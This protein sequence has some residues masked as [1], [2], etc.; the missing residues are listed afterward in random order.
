MTARNTYA[1]LAEYK[2]F[3]MS[4]GQPTNTDATD[5]AVIDSLLEQASRYIDGKTSRWFYPRI[6]TRYLS[7]PNYPYVE[8]EL[9]FDADVLEV[10]SF[11]NGDGSSI[12]ASEYNLWPANEFPKF[13]LRIKQSSNFQW[14]TDDSEYENVL[15]LKAVYGYHSNYTNEAWTSAGT[16]GASI[17]DTT[18]LAFTMTAGHSLAVG[19]IV[20]IDNEIFIIGTVATNTITPLKRGDNGS[21]AATHSNGTAVYV[22]NPMDDCKNAT[23][24][25]ATQAYKRRFGQSLSNSETV[26][27]S[28]VVLTPKDIPTMAGEF[29]HTYRRRV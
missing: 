24:E 15:P 2:S 14:L 16:L 5:D 29:I 27:A 13:G 21:T 23:L 12:A 10:V 22:W 3:V 18:T 6:E 26:T 28:G 9:D 17:S 25:I 19:N 7:I 1:T 20:R 8:R 11:L 4:R